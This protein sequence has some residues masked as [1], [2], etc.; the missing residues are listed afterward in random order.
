MIQF[1]A[2]NRI[3]A[4]EVFFEDLVKDARSIIAEVAGFLGLKE[5]GEH[6]LGSF[7]FR[8]VV[9]QSNAINDTWESRYR[10]ETADARARAPPTG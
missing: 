10:D 9:S 4:Y 6:N 7:D 8:A 3:G 5:S 1:F 2:R